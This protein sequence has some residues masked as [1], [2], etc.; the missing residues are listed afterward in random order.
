MTELEGGD[1]KMGVTVELVKDMVEGFSKVIDVSQIPK[2]NLWGSAGVCRGCPF[3]VKEKEGLKAICPFYEKLFGWVAMEDRFVYAQVGM[4]ENC[5][6]LV[7]MEKEGK[8][9]E[10]L[11]KEGE[12][13]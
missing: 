12:I 5:P 3:N 13:R 8:R 4:Y 7:W 10:G 11:R 9:V 2:K 1:E 6:I